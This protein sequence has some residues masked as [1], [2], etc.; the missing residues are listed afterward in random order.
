[1][2]NNQDGIDGELCPSGYP[3]AP[4]WDPVTGNLGTIRFNPF[5]DCAIKWQDRD[6]FIAATND[7]DGMGQASGS[8]AQISVQSSHLLLV[9]FLVSQV[10]AIIMDN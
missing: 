2:G 9:L 8:H 10:L 4:G 6:N 7:D 1:M 5:V 3:A